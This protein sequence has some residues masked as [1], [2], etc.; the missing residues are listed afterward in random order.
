MPSTAASRGEKHSNVKSSGSSADVGGLSSSPALSNKASP[1]ESRRD[2]PSGRRYDWQFG[3]YDYGV[4]ENPDDSVK[5]RYIPESANEL[6]SSLGL[7]KDDLEYLISYPEDQITPANLPFILRQIRIQ[8]TKRI[9]PTV[10]PIPAPEP[11]STGTVIGVE[12]HSSSSSPGVVGEECGKTVDRGTRSS[13]S[14]SVLLGTWDGRRQSGEPPPRKSQCPPPDQG[15]SVSSVPSQERSKRIQTR[16]KPTSLESVERRGFRDDQAATG[17]NRKRGKPKTPKEFV[18]EE[19]KFKETT[20]ETKRLGQ[21]EESVDS[22]TLNEA[23]GKEEENQEEEQTET[24][25]RPAKCEGDDSVRKVATKRE[26]E[27]EKE[28]T[29]VPPPT[30]MSLDK[31]L[32]TLTG[33]TEDGEKGGWSR[34]DG[35]DVRKPRED[36]AGPEAKRRRSRSPRVPADFEL[37]PLKLPASNEGENE[38]E[39]PPAGRIGQPG[40]TGVAPEPTP[41]VKPAS[42]AQAGNGDSSSREQEIE[43]FDKFGRR[44]QHLDLNNPNSWGRIASVRPGRI[45]H[46]RPFSH[47]DTWQWTVVKSQSSLLSCFAVVSLGKPSDRRDVRLTVY[48]HRGGPW[49]EVETM[50]KERGQFLTF[51]AAPAGHVSPPPPSGVL[52]Y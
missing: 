9:A 28:P 12:R 42:E 25:S 11:K 27:K 21:E 30:S 39:L 45:P 24:R 51:L 43:F 33:C 49:A 14:G 4:L 17:Q 16:S 15:S 48:G 40:E 26:R 34:G 10:P 38:R 7:E 50:E 1:G 3:E 19:E 46:R 6:L 22:E 5:Y 18:E 52:L 37:P 41:D 8:K 23:G 47:M 32:A 35:E 2:A 31:D 13:E 29:D 36:L 44:F 20:R